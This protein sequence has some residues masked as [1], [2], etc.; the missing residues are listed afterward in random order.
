MPGSRLLKVLRGMRGLTVAPFGRSTAKLS[1][2]PIVAIACAGALTSAASPA[3]GQSPDSGV[4]IFNI[5]VPKA[6]NGRSK[7]SAPV[8]VGIVHALHPH[9]GAEP[10]FV[11]EA[12]GE[13]GVEAAG[14]G[15]IASLQALGATHDLVFVDQRG[16]SL[17]PLL[18]P[19][20][21]AD[22]PPA[23]QTAPIL[24]A[25]YL[26]KC[27]DSFERHDDLGDLN[28]RTFAE[29]LE[30]VRRKLGYKR[31]QLIGYFY[32]TRIIQQYL[33]RWPKRVSA[34]VL[35]DVSPMNYPAAEAEVGALS[36]SVESTLQ[37]CHRDK[38]C[39]ARY[40][41]LDAEW[42][43]VSTLL[44]GKQIAVP[45]D[46]NA[47]HG[48]AKVSGAGIL[49]WMKLR[50]LRWVGAASWPRDVDAIA[51]GQLVPVVRQYAD[52]RRAT[53]ASYPLALR[54]AV[55]CAENMP[56]DGALLPK[57]DE[58]I[59]AEQ[60]ACANWPV[61]R[62]SRQFLRI[63]RA[64]IPILAVTADFDIEAPASVVRRAFGRSP[65]VQLVVFPNRARATDVDWD[66]CMG[67]LVTA[68]LQA[69]GRARLD[70]SCVNRL[71]RPAFAISDAQ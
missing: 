57:S 62:L 33:A 7:E 31:I 59:A 25:P 35:G 8:R 14:S 51:N 40:P 46:L 4:Q 54:I 43:R 10:I 49:Q 17:S 27:R 22:A 30:S 60:E 58:G 64:K 39:A 24:D 11:I 71:K 12:L 55:D 41:D 15:L 65:Q 38:A 36:G 37:A 34:A 47:A 53:L 26:A 50:T 66:D 69:P 6:Y 68:F 16:T 1:T 32:G 23:E 13:S 63:P 45:T 48:S 19:P 56:G 61:R 20:V 42:V 44:S 52:Y 29:D 2:G 3:F 9:A 5:R 67:P 70:T 28:S 18:C 21:S